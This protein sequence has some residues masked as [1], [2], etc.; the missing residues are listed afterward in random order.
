MSH[1]VFNMKGEIGDC[2]AES[3]AGGV[4]NTDLA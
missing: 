3:S 1:E 2:K 4:M